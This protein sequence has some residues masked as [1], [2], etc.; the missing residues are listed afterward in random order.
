[1]KY[2]QVIMTTPDRETAQRIAKEL[3]DRKLCACFQ[4]VGPIE[5][6]YW[7]EG[8]VES[9]SEYLCIIKTRE[10]LLEE[11]KETVQSLHPYEVPEVIATPIVGGNEGYFKWLDE[12]LMK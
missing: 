1:M 4:I 7:W 12:I 10:E 2:V 3:L 8:K 6:H 11:L 5:S 9:D